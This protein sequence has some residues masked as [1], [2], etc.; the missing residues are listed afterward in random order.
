MADADKAEC[1]LT[2]HKVYISKVFSFSNTPEWDIDADEIEHIYPDYELYAYAPQTHDQAYGFLTR[3]CPRN[4]DFC[5][6]SQMQG[7]ISHKVANLSEFWG[8]AED[9]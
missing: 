3:G 6:A 9:T 1:L 5:H 2:E 8:G 4:C 7:R